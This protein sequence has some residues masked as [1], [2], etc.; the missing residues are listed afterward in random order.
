[1]GESGSLPGGDGI[2]AKTWKGKHE[3]ETEGDKIQRSFGT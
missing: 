1:M 3:M 2:N